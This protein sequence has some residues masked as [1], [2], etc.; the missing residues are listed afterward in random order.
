MR[1][2]VL[3]AAAALF[4]M[5]A[6]GCSGYNQEPSAAPAATTPLATVAAESSCAGTPVALP[7]AIPNVPP[8]P[9]GVQTVT[10]SSGLRYA[11]LKAGTGDVAK[12]GQTATVQYTGWLPD[13]TKFDAS[14][15]HGQPLSFPL[16]A[17]QVIKG[18]DE[19]VAGMK[20]GGER[21]LIVPPDLG[22]GTKGAGG[23][24]IPPCATLIFD[25]QL[26]GVK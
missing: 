25:V 6:A 18:W 10:A 2:T 19:G 15:D 20:V 5:A 26:L 23:G 17:G 1:Q 3:L 24:V 8:I 13:G 21:L 11:D 16:G 9:A 4:L 12:S 14:A 7:S 22:Y